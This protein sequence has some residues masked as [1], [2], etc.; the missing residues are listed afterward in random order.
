MTRPL[1]IMTFGDS[2][3]VG[4][5]SPTAENPNGRTTPYGRFLQERL[6]GSAEVLVRGVNGELTGEMAMRLGTDVLPLR[7]DYVVILG[8]TND[9]G[10]GAQPQEVMRNL[11]TIYE[12]VRGSGARPVAV[13]LP[14]ILG[15]DEAIPP[16][17]TLN[18]L[19]L[20]YSRDK[21]QPAVDLFTA[22]AE[23]ETL[24]LAEAYSNDGLHL[25]TE[26][27]RLLADLLYQEVFS[28]FGSNEPAA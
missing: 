17:Q 4:Y 3:T 10:W 24:R 7:P 18:R 25:T 13:T 2:L 26:G 19:I 22:T 15:F 14:S 9:L 8:G 21:P 23:P 20:E 16:R 11:V 6:G 1:R 12:R 27:Y 5:Q 28:A